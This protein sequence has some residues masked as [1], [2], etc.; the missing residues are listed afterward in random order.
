[1][2]A[3]Q[4]HR[5][6]VQRHA[7]KDHME[8]HTISNLNSH[9]WYQ[10]C[11]KAFNGDIGSQCSSP[12]K[13]RTRESVPSNPPQNIIIN[14]HGKTRVFVQWL[15]PPVESRNGDVKGYE[16]SS[17]VVYICFS[18]GSDKTFYSP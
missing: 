6:L 15:P 2:T 10:I 18:A 9:A 3:G 14:K 11:V 5:V 16:V 1:M 17:L 13:V 8:S 4:P 7:S 12:L